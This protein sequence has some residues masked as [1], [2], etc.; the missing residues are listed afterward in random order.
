MS[1]KCW[2]LKEWLVG[3]EKH[4]TKNVVSVTHKNCSEYT[5]S[6]LIV[7][8]EACMGNSS[9]LVDNR[10]LMECDNT[11]ALGH[12]WLNNNVKIFYLCIYILHIY[13][14]QEQWTH[15]HYIWYIQ[16]IYIFELS[17]CMSMLWWKL[18]FW[19]PWEQGE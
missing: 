12:N 1:G 16:Q 8:I 15:G 18:Y 4:Q 7:Y 19:P 13:Y 3:V 6:I 11:T 14:N 2:S 10:A 17:N 9:M 5:S